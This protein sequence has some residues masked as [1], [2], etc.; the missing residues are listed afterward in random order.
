MV[1][2]AGGGMVIAECDALLGDSTSVGAVECQDGAPLQCESGGVDEGCT[3]PHSYLG[4]ATVTLLDAE[5][6]AS[7]FVYLPSFEHT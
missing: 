1:F 4:G 5:T 6:G 2:V 3:E 7:L